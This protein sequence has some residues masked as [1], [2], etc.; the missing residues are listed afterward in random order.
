MGRY[1]ANRC[2]AVLPRETVSD[3][4]ERGLTMSVVDQ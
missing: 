3:I 4:V 2:F 1:A